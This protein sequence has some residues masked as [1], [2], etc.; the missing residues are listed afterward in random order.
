MRYFILSFDLP[1]CCYLFTL[2]TIIILFK[3]LNTLRVTRSTGFHSTRVCM[4]KFTSIY[5]ANY[6]N[7]LT[8]IHKSFILFTFTFWSCCSIC[9]ICTSKTIRPSTSTSSTLRRAGFTLGGLFSCI[10][11]FKG[12]TFITLTNFWLRLKEI[13]FIFALTIFN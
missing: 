12:F 10:Y 3:A 6:T 1:I 13:R 11:K 5:I 8:I 9:C 4:D 2:S 7:R